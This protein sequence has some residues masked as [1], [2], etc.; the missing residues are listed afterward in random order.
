MRVCIA[1][2]V[3]TVGLLS[4]GYIGLDQMSMPT[5][6]KPATDRSTTSPTPQVTL[7][8][9][10]GTTTKPTQTGYLLRS[11]DGRLAIYE[12]ATPQPGDQPLEIL[13]FQ[14]RVL[15]ESDQADLEKGIFL[16]DEKALQALLEDFTG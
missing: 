10:P 9:R 16:K 2:L 15:P 13:D 14:V 4:F 1:A 11:L 5:T 8:T 7:T 12:G 6:P 3:I